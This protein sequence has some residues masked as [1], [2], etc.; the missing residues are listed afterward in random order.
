MTPVEFYLMILLLVV[1][2]AAAIGVKAAYQNGVTDGYGFSQE[3]RNPGY[4]LAGDYLRQYMSHRWPKL[5]DQHD[6]SS[7]RGV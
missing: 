3:P 7:Q 6:Q 4:R 1:T 2:G 5:K